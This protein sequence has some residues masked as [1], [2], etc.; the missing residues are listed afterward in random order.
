MNIVGHI[1]VERPRADDTLAFLRG[2]VWPPRIYAVKFQPE[3]ESVFPEKS[4][5][6]EWTQP[7]EISS[8]PYLRSEPFAV[9]LRDVGNLPYRKRIKNPLYLLAIE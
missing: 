8:S 2:I 6:V 1:V 4:L 3:V 7:V 5:D 9:S